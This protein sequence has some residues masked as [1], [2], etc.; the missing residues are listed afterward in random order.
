MSEEEQ[1]QESGQLQ[2]PKSPSVHS[3]DHSL[4]YPLQGNQLNSGLSCQHF[5]VQCYLTRAKCSISNRLI[6]Y[7]CDNWCEANA[8][9]TIKWNMQMRIFAR[10]KGICMVSV[11]R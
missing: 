4:L 6:K 5:N 3:V 1:Q 2:M 10:R 11:R 7:D 8:T 9:W